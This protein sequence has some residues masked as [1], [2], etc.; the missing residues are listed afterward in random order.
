MVLL[1]KEMLKIDKSMKQHQK[2]YLCVQVD[3]EPS[4][5]CVL[6]RL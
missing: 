1:L 4:Q 5:R 3:V 6:E 2:A